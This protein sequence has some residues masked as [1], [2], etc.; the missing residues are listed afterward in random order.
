MKSTQN[1]PQ[2][3]KELRNQHHYSQEELAEK[4]NVTRQAISRW[5][6]GKAVPDIDNLLFL[7]ELYDVPLDYLLGEELTHEEEQ[8]ACNTKDVSSIIEMLVLSTIL[9][10]SSN[11]LVLGIPVAIIIMLWLILNK[12]FYKILFVLCI[13]C[14]IIGTY[15]I[16]IV[17]VHYNTYFG[18]SLFLTK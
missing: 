18:N 12:R 15:A 2:R 7:S 10:L 16:F 6:N 1:L 4:L 11:I 8:H 9:L 3:L 5:E 17:Y 13:L 14:I